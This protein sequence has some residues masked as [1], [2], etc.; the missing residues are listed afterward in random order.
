MR[1]PI[2]IPNAPPVPAR[3]PVAPRSR[4]GHP[5]LSSTVAAA[6]PSSTGEATT[7]SSTTTPPLPSLGRRRWLPVQGRMAAPPPL[8][9]PPA[10]PRSFAARR[11]QICLPLLSST[12]AAATAAPRS[13][14]GDLVVLGPGLGLPPPFRA[15]PSSSSLVLSPL[16][17]PSSSLDLYGQPPPADSCWSSGAP[18]V[19]LT[20]PHLLPLSVR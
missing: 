5:L 15:S 8:D 13:C 10:A 16:P 3:T 11:P 7:P 19:Y 18:T 2:L 14:T 20:C 6:T 9:L 4:S 17:P 12:V 1:P